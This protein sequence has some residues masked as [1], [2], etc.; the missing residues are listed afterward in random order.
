ME[1][2]TKDKREGYA[3]V[4]LPLFVGLIK[5][6]EKLVFEVQER[7][8]YVRLGKGPAVVLRRTYAERIAEE[9]DVRFLG[10]EK[11]GS[12]RRVYFADDPKGFE[13]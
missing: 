6:Y 9:P 4:A 13:F 2:F 1:K 7:L 10:M 12:R 3:R 5:E 8:V 11:R